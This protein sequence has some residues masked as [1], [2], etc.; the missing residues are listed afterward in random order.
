MDVA[1]NKGFPEIVEM[2]LQ[3]GVDVNYVDPVRHHHHHHLSSFI[4][5]LQY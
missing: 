3:A 2:F 4:F 1:A 5:F